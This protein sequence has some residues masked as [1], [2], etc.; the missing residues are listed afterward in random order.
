MRKGGMGLL[1]QNCVYSFL[2]QYY[3]PWLEA[4]SLMGKVSEAIIS[5]THLATM[6]KVSSFLPQLYLA[7]ANN[8][9]KSQDLPI[10]HD[11]IHDCRRFLLTYRHVITYAPEQIY[12][13]GLIFS[14]RHST[15]RKNFKNIVPQWVRLQPQPHEKW[16]ASLQTLEGHSGVVN[17]A[18]FSPDGQLVA[19]GSGDRTVRLWDVQTGEC[20]SILED[21]SDQVYTVV[22]SPDGRLVA[23]GS[24]DGTVRLWDAQTGEC[25]SILQGHSHRVDTVVFSPDGQLVA[26][27]SKDR[28]VRLWDAQTGECR[29]ILQGHSDLVRTVVFSPDG[30]LVA[31]GSVDRTVRLWDT[32]T[33]DHVL[34]IPH[35][36]GN[37][38]I[39]FRTKLGLIFVDGKGFEVPPGKMTKAGVDG[40]NCLTS[41]IQIDHTGEWVMKSSERVLWLPPEY[42]PTAHAIYG[43]TIALGSGNGY[44]SFLW[45]NVEDGLGRKVDNT[46]S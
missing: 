19:S 3:L 8:E 36:S 10:V 18:V 34:H 32:Q 45:F 43:N 4:M 14:P 16:S 5:I 20:R 22:F 44:V 41:L 23:S 13:S 12:I 24:W 9:H 28:T 38:K 29:S 25:R 33:G 30:Q 27:G 26:S 2:R 37:P 35:L 39:E 11:L 1:D 31:S 42:R 17:V 21:H 15:V 46:S 40:S 7:N 6:I